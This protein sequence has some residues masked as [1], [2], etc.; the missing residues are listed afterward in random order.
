MAR[1]RQKRPALPPPCAD[2]RPH[3]GAWRRDAYTGGLERCDCPRGQALRDFPG[4]CRRLKA[5]QQPP[6]K[7]KPY[8]ATF[9]GRMAATG[10]S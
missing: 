4:Y 7:A 2:C 10:E 6:P 5:A 8:Q 3:D 1:K 9:D